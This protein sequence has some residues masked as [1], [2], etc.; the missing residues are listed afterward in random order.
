MTEELEHAVAR[1]SSGQGA[2]ELFDALEQNREAVEK[3][4]RGVSRFV[5]YTLMRTAEGGLSV[6]VC[7]DKAGYDASVQATGN[8]VRENVKTTV[9]PPQVLV[10][11]VTLVL[12]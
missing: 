6:P 5:A 9:S 10:G 12:M 4:L 11:N 3:L 1:R 8:W 2:S 7:R